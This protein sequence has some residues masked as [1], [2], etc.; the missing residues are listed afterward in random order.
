MKKKEEIFVT[1]SS[2]PPLE[3][4]LPY[5]KRLWESRFLT[6]MGEFHEQ[7]KKELSAYLL[8]EDTELFV[9]GHIALELFKIDDDSY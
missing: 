4:F 7:L 2:L 9:N 3:E 1:K 5:M 6:N 8:V